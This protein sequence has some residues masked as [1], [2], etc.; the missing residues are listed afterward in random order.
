MARNVTHHGIND[1][2]GNVYALKKVKRSTKWLEEAK[3]NIVLNKNVKRATL[4]VAPKREA[5]ALRLQSASL[6]LQ[7]TSAQ[8]VRAAS[9]PIAS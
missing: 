8:V 3:Q 6:G 9:P 5:I 4:K 1:K 2:I 7:S